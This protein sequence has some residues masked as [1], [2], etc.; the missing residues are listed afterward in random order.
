MMRECRLLGHDGC[1]IEHAG[2]VSELS[3]LSERNALRMTV[4][5]GMTGQSTTGDGP[6]EGCAGCNETDAE[7]DPDTIR[8]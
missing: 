6:A 5:T 8:Q 3:S 1:V 7:P 4:V 2:S